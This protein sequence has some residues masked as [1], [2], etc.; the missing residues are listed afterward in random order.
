MAEMAKKLHFLKNGTEQTSKIYTTASEA[1]NNYISVKVDGTTGYVPIN[2]ISHG[3]A[4]IGRVIKRLYVK[5]VMVD[6]PWKQPVLSANG[7]MGGSEFAC[8]ASAYNTESSGTAT[9][10][11]GVFDNNT[12]TY[13]RSGTTSGWIQ[14]YNPV[15][16]KVSAI[17]WGYFYCYPTGGNVQ[18]SNDGTTWD[19]LNTWT[20]SSEAD[21]TI[22]L[23]TQQ[24]YKYYRINITGVNKDVIHAHSLTIT[25][26]YQKEVEKYVGQHD[27]Y[28]YSTTETYAILSSYAQILSYHG[29][30]E[31]LYSGDNGI[32]ATTVGN[33]ALFGGNS[34]YLTAYNK[35]L[36]RSQIDN[37]WGVSLSINLAATTVGNYALFGGGGKNAKIKN[38]VVD[39]K[40]T[41]SSAVYAYDTSLTKSIPTSLSVARRYLSAT[42]VGNYALFGGGVSG[43]DNNID[44]STVDAYD[45]SLTNSIPT[46]LST[47]RG[48]LAATTVGNYALFGGGSSSSTVDAYNTSLTRTTQTALS[49]DRGNLAATT[50]GNYALFGGG[51]FK[52]TVD[53]YDTSLT[54]H[55]P[56]AL[57]SNITG[58]AATTV[59]NY[60][61]FG[62]GAKFFGKCNEINA[63]DTSLTKS[64]PTPLSE[65]RDNLAATTV[66]N[67]ALFGG[68]R[69]SSTVDVYRIS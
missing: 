69:G 52:N 63:Y 42:A 27:D 25:A 65:A 4:T 36:T 28:D 38:G 57:T 33:Y 48:S 43:T 56:T 53:A 41:A 39:T 45:T 20:N 66:G 24:Y 47:A 32:A 11:W 31:S 18:G 58:L 15:P 61:L 49:T 64:A 26:T 19:T 9:D 55:T 10:A 16:L 13:W 14:F 50:V 29:T 21:F 1:G 34:R 30:I 67:Y 60:A 68:G 2:D 6:E 17:K 51:N 40:G 62:G 35:S 5:K 44:K 23:S 7:T 12:N 37:S 3:N 46:A 59:G 22:N 8:S 54:R